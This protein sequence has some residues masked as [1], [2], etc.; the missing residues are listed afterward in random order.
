MQVFVFL[1]NGNNRLSSQ[2]ISSLIRVDPN[3]SGNRKRA[4]AMCAFVC[5]CSGV[6][7]SMGVALSVCVFVIG[8]CVGTVL[9]QHH[10]QLA[11]TCNAAKEKANKSLKTKQKQKVL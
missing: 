6:S 4:T 9:R 7:F 5:F 1:G 11:S 8:A 10:C 2:D 3:F